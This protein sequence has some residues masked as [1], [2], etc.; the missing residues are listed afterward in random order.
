MTTPTT[1]PTRRPAWRGL[2]ATFRALL[3]GLLCT[4]LVLGG[5]GAAHAA[6]AVPKASVKLVTGPERASGYQGQ[7]TCDPKERPGT[8]AL[9]SLLARTYGAN[10]GGIVRSC[11][12][13]GRSEH[14]EGRA[15][16]WMLNA[17][18]SADRSKADKFI[19]W[20][21]GKDSKGVKAGNARRLGVQYVIWNKR[22]WSSWDGRWKKYEGANPHTDHVH[23]SLSWNGAMKRTSFWTGKAVTK[24]DH[25]PCVK[26]KGKLAPKYTK[27]NYR[28]C[29]R[30]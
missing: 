12:S 5:A 2:T 23:I 11:S 8:V 24:V 27:P 3:M 29:P 18:R 13:G 21:T 19:V 26:K 9:R 15:Y 7:V 28:P 16:D 25:G 20:L 6:L 14:K 10:K 17:N 22:M 4:G 1:A 30:V